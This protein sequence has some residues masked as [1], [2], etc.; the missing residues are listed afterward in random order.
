[1]LPVILISCAGLAQDAWREPI[2]PKAT[3]LW[4]TIPVVT[5]GNQPGQ[6]PSDAL[7]LFDGKDLNQWTAARGSEPPWEVKDGVMTVKPNTGGI[8]TR[9]TFG[10]VQLHIEWRSPASIKGGRPGS[11]QQRCVP[12]RKI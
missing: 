4:K 2:D 9:M 5:P 8:K 7:V 6:P 3:Q 12:A 10:D 11:R 1:L